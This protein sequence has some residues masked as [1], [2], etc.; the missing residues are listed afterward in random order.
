M[1]ILVYLFWGCIF[2]LIYPYLIYP[3]ILHLVTKLSA[4]DNSLKQ[5]IDDWPSVSMIISAYNEDK[6]IDEKLQNTEG[7]EYPSSKFESI[8][9]SDASEDNT[10]KIVREWAGRNKNIRLL[11]QNDRGGKTAGLNRGVAAATGEIIVFSDANAMYEKN[12]L[13]ELVKYFANPDIGYVMGAALYSTDKDS[14]A[15]ES[16]GLYW[17]YEV[18]LKEL[19][20]KFYS[21]VGG[22]GAIYAIRRELFWNLDDDDI[23][24]FVN[25]LQIVSKGYRGLFNVDAICYEAP[26]GEF[27]KEFSRKRRIVNRSWRAILKHIHRFHLL[28]HY[29][30]LFQLV[31]HKIIRW[32]SLFILSAII[33][34]NVFLV[35]YNK[36]SVFILILI[37]IILSIVLA[38]LGY[39]FDKKRKPMPKLIYFSYYF[40][41]VSLAA[42]LGIYDNF[43]GR[44]Y[45]Y[46]R[47]HRN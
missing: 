45:V 26:A 28:R 20:S 4:K 16:E 38:V 21:V 6:V 17:K 19:E 12:A 39:F 40:Y 33:V 46:W 30:F 27:D 31:S 14:A 44:K 7:L 10:D 23:N 1:E 18:Y 34:S 47:Q 22:D 42:I 43:R 35:I 25:P 13:V 8:V 3:I 15:A 29:K 41:L 5:F 36:S 9:V 11:R 37:G 2:L 24:D 32:F